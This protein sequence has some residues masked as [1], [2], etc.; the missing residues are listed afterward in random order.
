MDQIY[1]LVTKMTTWQTV[2]TYR[3]L[4]HYFI[5]N[6]GF[7]SAFVVALVVALIGIAIFYG[8]IGTSV[9]RLA[10]VPVWLI[11]MIVVGVVTFGVTQAV[12]IGSN[13]AQTGVFSDI[14]DFSAIQ[15]QGLPSD[16]VPQFTANVQ[17]LKERLDSVS[18][19]V[20]LALNIENAVLS[21]LLFFLISIGVKKLPPF[22]KYIPF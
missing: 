18:C 4:P 7:T 6:G 3:F 8:W 15:Q 21:M 5:D 10:T 20:V 12:I 19:D 13:A 22:T 16:L 14:V 17:N 9:D 1:F 2:D 11:T